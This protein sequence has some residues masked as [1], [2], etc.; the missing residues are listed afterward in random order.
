ME[1]EKKKR[2]E[3]ETK[4][5][6]GYYSNRPQFGSGGTSK[7]FREFSKGMTYFI[8]IAA[9]IA[10]YFGLLRS[11]NLM[12]G[13]MKVLDVLKPILYGFLVAFLLN[14]I[15]KLVDK[16][17]EPFLSKHL[18]NERKVHTISRMSGI[19]LA[20]IVMT[21]LITL[22]CNM[23]IPELYRS[24]RNLVF[25]LPR[26]L[27]Q[28]IM[29]LNQIEV[30]SSNMGVLI[31]TF[32]TEA[33]ETF[34][35]WLSNNFVSRAND[36]MTVL[37]SGMI[38]F[39][40]EIFDFLIGIIVSIY[41]LY[42]KEM[43]AKQAKKITYAILSPHHANIV[44]HITQKANE[45][46][47]GF[48]VGKVVD[49]II[50]GFL[51]FLGLSILN[52]P[53][54]LLVS[55]IVGVTNVIPFFGPYIGAIP[56]AILIFLADPIKGFYFLVFILA[57]QQLDGN[58]IGPKILGNST[59]LTSFW[60]IFAILFGGGMFGFMGMLLGVPTFAVIY[61]IIHLAV[62]GRLKNKN[63]PEESEYYDEFSFVDDTGK[64]VISKENLEKMKKEREEKEDADSGTER[65]SGKRNTGA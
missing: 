7:L 60:V 28:L 64:Y 15:V 27:N 20:L 39:V 44:L 41:V 3:K 54:I 22:L 38:N 48:F 37:T 17:L 10:F 16:Y 57:L 18:K 46:F 52:M 14:P 21:A 65:S 34:Q 9:A 8:V 30:D 31:S 19:I 5:P 42:S 53:Y 56:S 13:F 29:K 1:E 45:I 6:E 36:I 11:T 12:A 51:C 63:L 62:N 40:G 23:L 43:F 25:T 4:T 32:L 49:S 50:I 24:I 35:E 26:Q 61:Y 47:G 33:T 55:V 58:F 59:G 2:Q